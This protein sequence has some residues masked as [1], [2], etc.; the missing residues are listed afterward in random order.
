[1]N[2]A[3]RHARLCYDHVAGELGVAL[4]SRLVEDGYIALGD[5][6]GEV[7]ASGDEFLSSFGVDLASARKRC[8]N[9]CKAYLDWTER[10]HH[11]AGAVGAALTKRLFDLGWIERSARGRTLIVTSAGYQGLRQALSL[12]LRKP[13]PGQ[14]D[15]QNM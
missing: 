3:L 15:F 12:D 13:S 7:T 10:R 11:L 9:Y 1:M 5:E 6:S 2:A 8:R 14:T 4:T